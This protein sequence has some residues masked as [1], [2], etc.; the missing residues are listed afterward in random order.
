[1]ID[2]DESA[3]SRHFAFPCPKLRRTKI[4]WNELP[5]VVAKPCVAP[6]VLHSIAAHFLHELGAAQPSN[7]NQRLVDL[8]LDYLR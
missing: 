4:F 5:T 7:A 1:V 8:R 3:S 2:E 6:G